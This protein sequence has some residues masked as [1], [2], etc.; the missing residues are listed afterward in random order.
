MNAG[1]DS[2]LFYK[3]LINDFNLTAEEAKTAISGIERHYMRIL[4]ALMDRG[5]KFDAKYIKFIDIYNTYREFAVSASR[6]LSVE[7]CINAMRGNIVPILD[8]IYSEKEQR[9]MAMWFLSS[10]EEES[11]VAFEKAIMLGRIVLPDDYQ[12]VVKAKIENLKHSYME[13]I[14]LDIAK[15]PNNFGFYLSKEFNEIIAY[16]QRVIDSNPDA[17][18]TLWDRLILEQYK[19]YINDAPDNIILRD[20]RDY[21][22]RYVA[23]QIIPREYKL[24]KFMEKRRGGHFEKQ[25]TKYENESYALIRE[26][27][28]KTDAV[29]WLIGTKYA[30]GIYIEDLLSEEK[31]KYVN[32]YSKIK[33][34]KRYFDFEES[35][36][37]ST[38]D[39][40]YNSYYPLEFVS[41]LVRQED[42]S[43]DG[44][45]RKTGKEM[46]YTLVN[47][48]FV[49]LH[50]YRKVISSEN[51]LRFLTM[52]SCGQIMVLTLSARAGCSMLNFLPE[53]YNIIKRFVIDTSYPNVKRIKSILQ[54]DTGGGTACI[55]LDKAY[56]GWIGE[57]WN[58]ERNEYIQSIAGA[59]CLND[60]VQYTLGQNT[61]YK[62]LSDC[63]YK[64]FEYY[65][66]KCL[67]RLER[68]GD[69]GN[70]Y[71]AQFVSCE[72]M[73]KEKGCLQSS[74]KF[75]NIIISNGKFRGCERSIIDTP[76]YNKERSDPEKRER[77]IE[78]IDLLMDHYTK[79]GD[80]NVLSAKLFEKM[81]RPLIDHNREAIE[82]VF[83][84][85]DINCDLQKT[86]IEMTFI[87]E[88]NTLEN[89]YDKDRG[90]LLLKLLREDLRVH[91]NYMDIGNS[92]EKLVDLI[93]IKIS[94]SDYEDFMQLLISCVSDMTAEGVE[95]GTDTATKIYA[96]LEGKMRKIVSVIRD[97]PDLP[98]ED[99]IKLHF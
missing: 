36:F 41:A 54:R 21:V 5:Y 2:L 67:F 33:E 39:T 86:I 45:N 44:G 99:F 47:G 83:E 51:T 11:K 26:N 85:L 28:Q 57:F 97:L 15:N 73:P 66:Q 62:I 10:V 46:F 79:L 25:E 96:E 88:Y 68:V 8:K 80:L 74:L 43:T 32:S 9:N 58:M 14:L 61:T 13:D 55:L 90:E 98:L 6:P 38:I 42:R 27:D 91:P 82:Y 34:L 78:D 37:A 72:P 75:K 81:T 56:K 12:A 64:M 84:V 87:R 52:N 40:E 17:D 71:D 69:M 95:S 18:S 4:A 30:E 65:D 3:I 22:D 92:S 1:Q 70:L 77:E 63:D 48:G 24:Y 29:K 20:N 60:I 23:Y 16:A 76:K 89:L 7:S 19:D 94:E 53:D 35:D 59:M 93:E 49:I 31:L 50:N